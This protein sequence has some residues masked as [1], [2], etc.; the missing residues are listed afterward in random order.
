MQEKPPKA[1]SILLMVL[2]LADLGVFLWAF[3]KKWIWI[4]LGPGWGTILISFFLC[5][6]LAFLVGVA[7]AVILA[8]LFGV[9]LRKKVR[10]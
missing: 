8:L 2:L 3:Y 7:I 4:D 10:S 9:P 6:L 1:F 5:I